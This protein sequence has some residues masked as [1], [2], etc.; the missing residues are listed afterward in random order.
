MLLNRMCDAVNVPVIA[1]GGAGAEAHFAEVFTQTDVDAA[2]AASIFHFGEIPHSATQI[3]S[4]TTK[5]THTMNPDFNKGKGL[6]PV[7]VQ[8]HLSLQVL[9]LGYMNEAAFAQTKETGK[10]TFFSR[11]RNELWTKGETSGNYL[12]VKGIK[13]DCDRDTLLVKAE[14]TGPTC[15]TGAWTCFEQ[16]EKGSFLHQ[17]QALIISRKNE[18]K[19]SSYTSSLFEKGINKIAQK[20]GEEAT[21]LIIEAKDNDRD[22]FLNE[23]ADLMF[24]LLVLLA[25]KGFEL[26]D[27]EAVLRE[28]NG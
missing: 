17:L 16:E 7:I 9:M 1:S 24:H 6:V 12:L 10:V 13:L 23:A 11:S 14:P 4:Q 25:E 8:H 5:H 15:H 18:P 19:P 28:R 21:E 22:L 27:V 2:L 20:V 3:I 26:S